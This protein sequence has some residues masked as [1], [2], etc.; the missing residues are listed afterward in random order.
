MVRLE[1]ILE[2]PVY[3]FNEFQFQYGSIRSGLLSCAR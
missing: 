1:A 2:T 3:D